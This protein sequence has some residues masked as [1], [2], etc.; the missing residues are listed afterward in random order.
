L[1]EERE[2]T[3]WWYLFAALLGILGGVI[4]YF[5]TKERDPR[6]AKNFLYVGI[7]TNLLGFVFIGLTYVQLENSIFHPVQVQNNPLSPLQQCLD[8]I[9]A[10]GQVPGPASYSACLGSSAPIPPSLFIQSWSFGQGTI[11]IVVGNN[12]T[13]DAYIGSLVI[14][15]ASDT[16]LYYQDTCM[17][18][19]CSFMNVFD[20]IG[21]QSKTVQVVPE[22]TN[23]TTFMGYLVSPG[24]TATV[25]LTYH[26]APSTEYNIVVI[27]QSGVLDYRAKPISPS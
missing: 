19:T 15:N 27:D 11:S 13:V 21:S 12:G 1:A 10:Q 18:Q 3:N 23:G 17:S 8:K 5:L 20:Y 2:V 7:T 4:S 24:S 16:E 25:T 6:K 22:D 14:V 9:Y 26:W